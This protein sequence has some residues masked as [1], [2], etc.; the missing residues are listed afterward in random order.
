MKTR[1]RFRLIR[2]AAVCLAATAFLAPP[3]SA[4]FP[5]ADGGSYAG[6]IG[7]IVRPDDRA[8]P[9]GPGSAPTTDTLVAVGI[10]RP[11]DRADPRGPGSA[12]VTDGLGRPLDPA[13]VRDEGPRAAEE[14]RSAP[15]SV[16]MDGSQNPGVAA[17]QAPASIV[18]QPT[19]FDWR[20]A[21]IGMAVGAALVL[22]L[23]AGVLV[24]GRRRDS[25]A[26]V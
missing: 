17:P 12:L 20:D 26:Q 2:R 21:G 8:D 9:R 10:V 15:P 25:L 4:A 19:G 22:A 7:G 18:V 1:K 14:P 3:A 6:V 24:V 11:D 13:A 16:R 5:D 23:A